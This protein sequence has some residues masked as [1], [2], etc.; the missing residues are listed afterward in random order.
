MWSLP[1][2][3]Q[4]WFITDESF[5]RINCAKI[6]GLTLSYNM[7]IC[8]KSDN[9]C[10]KSD[11]ICCKYDNIYCNL[12]NI[13]C[14]SGD[15]CCQS[16]NICCKSGDMYLWLALD[17]LGSRAIFVA[18][19]L[20]QLF[21]WHGHWCA[22]WLVG[23]SFLTLWFECFRHQM[24]ES[25]IPNLLSLEVDEWAEKNYQN[26]VPSKLTRQDKLDRD[27]NYWLAKI[28]K[29]LQLMCYFNT[30]AIMHDKSRVWVFDSEKLILFTDIVFVE[31]DSTTRDIAPNCGCEFSLCWKPRLSAKVNHG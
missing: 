20:K 13:C 15:I 5:I 30:F 1:D 26:S 6:E 2:N 16:G 3:L 18:S 19:S 28:W 9:L 27:S 31:C 8:C 10:C 24:L 25:L 14:K 4:S 23:Y 21:A 29:T 12:D 17:K 11:N 22:G 7:L